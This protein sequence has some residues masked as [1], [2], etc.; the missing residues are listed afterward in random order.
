MALSAAMSIRWAFVLAFFGG[1]SVIW[2]VLSGLLALIAG[3]GVVIGSI[4]D[5]GLWRGVYFAFITARTI[6][7]GDLVPTHRLSQ[8]LAV[9]VGFAGITMTELVAAPAV[10]AIQL[11]S[12]G[13][14]RD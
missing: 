5:G 2:P 6:G 10:R 7:Y 1:L 8:G 9:L 11:S 13:A 4:E 12:S 3:A 14:R